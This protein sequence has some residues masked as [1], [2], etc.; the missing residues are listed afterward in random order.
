MAVWLGSRLVLKVGRVLARQPAAPEDE[1]T[2]VAVPTHNREQDVALGHG[3][4]PHAWDTAE[5][6]LCA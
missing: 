5:T 6:S 1:Q 3:G 4:G 2:D